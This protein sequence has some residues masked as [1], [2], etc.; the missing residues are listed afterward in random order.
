MTTAREAAFFALYAALKEEAFISDW[1]SQWHREENPSSKDF[2]LAQEIAMGACRMAMTL[3][4]LAKNL[5]PNHRL[6][7]KVKEKTLLRTA[8]YQA[9][10]MDRIPLH[11]IA[12]ETVAIAKKHG[13]KEKAGF[14]NALLRKLAK[15]TPHLPEGD[16]LAALSIRYSFPPDLIRTFIESYGKERTLEILTHS[17]K[18]NP[19]MA[20]VRTSTDLADYERVPVLFMP[21]I[22]LRNA[23]QLKKVSSSSDFYIQNITSASHV[24]LLAKRISQPPRKILDLC[25]SP[26]GKLLLAHDFFPEAFLFAND[27]TGGKIEK[28][29]QNLGKYRIEANLTISPGE[30]YSS[31]E[32]FDLII[33]DL[34]CSNTG[35]LSKRPEARWRFNEQKLH[36]LEETQLKIIGNAASLLSPHGKIWLMTCSLIPSENEGLAKKASACFNL[37]K[38]FEHLQFPTLEGFEG[39][40][41]AELQH[42]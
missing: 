19:I 12:M 11:A 41:A 16:S 42:A 20:R 38:T 15:E 36:A 1:L 37:R 26:G 17:N 4:A 6:D 39:G 10:M 18:P 32:K 8:I 3:D 35:V 27:I 5:T 13:M 34:P 14:F 25:A 29:K 21:F 7:L 2:R 22:F 30:N 33:C 23:A 9:T 40:Y 31:E 28:L 24:S